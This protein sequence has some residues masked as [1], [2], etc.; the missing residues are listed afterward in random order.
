[1]VMKIGFVREFR[2]ALYKGLLN[3]EIVL[4]SEGLG[5]FDMHLS[6]SPMTLSA[7]RQ[8]CRRR[9]FITQKETIQ[10]PLI[11]D[12]AEWCLTEHTWYTEYKKMF[13]CSPWSVLLKPGDT[14][15]TY[16]KCVGLKSGPN[17][18]KYLK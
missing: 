8:I 15:D 9:S 6:N 5:E 17:I 7:G 14:S 11:T 3:M 1:M 16:P 12:D 4:R 2:T 13:P 18:L 10:Q